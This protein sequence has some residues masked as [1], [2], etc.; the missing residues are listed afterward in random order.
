MRIKPEGAEETRLPHNMLLGLAAQCGMAGGLAAA[1]CLALPLLLGWLCAGP[2]PAGGAGGIQ[3]GGSAVAGHPGPDLPLLFAAQVGL[4]AWS[5]HSLA[6][7][8]FEIA[9]FPALVGILTVVLVQW[10]DVSESRAVPSAKGRKAR[11]DE[12]YA[13]TPEPV[14]PATGV[15]WSRLSRRALAAAALTLATLSMANVWRWPGEQAYQKAYNALGGPDLDLD[16]LR[17]QVEAAGRLLPTSPQPWQLLGRAAEASN[18][19]RLAV[20]AY[21]EAVKRSPHRAS[22]HT[23]LAR[24]CLGLGDYAGARRAAAA[25]LEWYPFSP[26]HRD[27]AAQIE[28]AARKAPPNPE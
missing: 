5:L 10:R 13:V 27:L 2:A 22:F 11:R 3:A 16:S 19:Y 28:A 25:A 18:A 1:A 26:G 9:C 17:T 12:R 8:N 20:A 14:T 15:P 24:N 7:F 4:A 21:G 23:H 6:D